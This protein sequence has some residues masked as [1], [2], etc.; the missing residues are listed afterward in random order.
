MFN[1]NPYVWSCDLV[2]YSFILLSVK[3]FSLVLHIKTSFFS[4]VPA[5]TSVYIMSQQAR[6]SLCLGG[7]DEDIINVFIMSQASGMLKQE[8]SV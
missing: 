7:A 1:S 4:A 8:L 2:S 6:A 3:G 5:V